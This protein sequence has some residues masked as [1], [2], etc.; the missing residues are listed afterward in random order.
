[1]LIGCTKD[2]EEHYTN[3]EI[4]NHPAWPSPITERNFNIKVI[5]VE[6]Q[7]FV[8][9]NYEDNIEY[10]IYQEDV[11]RYLKDLKS[12]VCFYRASLKEPECEKEPN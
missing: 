7:L 2:I 9:M 11:L 12:V 3:R 1:M 10:Q 8:G 4:I 6:G 5:V